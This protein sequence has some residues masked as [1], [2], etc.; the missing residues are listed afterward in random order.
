M[1]KVDG[2]RCPEAGGF[3][4]EFSLLVRVGEMWPCCGLKAH[5][6]ESPAFFCLTLN[7]SCKLSLLFFFVVVVC[8]CV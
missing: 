8:V 2:V 6:A 7:F 4:C 5:P 3:V 1:L